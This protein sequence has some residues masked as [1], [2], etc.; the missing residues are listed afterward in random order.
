MPRNL[1]IPEL[2]PEGEAEL[3]ILV[4]AFR[5]IVAQFSLNKEG[6]AVLEVMVDRLIREALGRSKPN[7]RMAYLEQWSYFLVSCAE[8]AQGQP[9]EERMS[10]LLASLREFRLQD[11]KGRRGAVRPE[12]HPKANCW[13]EKD[14]QRWEAHAPPVQEE[15][16][17]SIVL[18]DW[19]PLQKHTSGVTGDESS[20]SRFSELDT[21]R[22]EPLRPTNVPE[23]LRQEYEKI[24]DQL[25]AFEDIRHRD[26]RSNLLAD[27]PPCWQKRWFEARIT[28]SNLALLV[29]A[30]RVGWIQSVE[31]LSTLREILAGA[32]VARRIAEQRIASGKEVRIIQ[33]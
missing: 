1:E 20:R 15:S 22:A 21:A 25:K 13:I 16:E 31:N 7:R 12:M 28:K 30:Y 24:H 9:P 3:G 19:E 18:T 2:T 33:P 6:V 26:V 32:R 23:S 17:P 5:D 8:K 29:A 27:I 10:F 14:G 11:A 4:R